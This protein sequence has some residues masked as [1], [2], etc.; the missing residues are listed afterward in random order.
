MFPLL[1][2]MFN[3]YS[4]GGADSGGSVDRGGSRPGVGSGYCPPTPLDAPRKFE[5]MAKKQR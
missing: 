2:W 4:V 5:A 1:S 3:L